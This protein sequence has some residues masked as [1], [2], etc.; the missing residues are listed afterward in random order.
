MKQ[1]L[2]ILFMIHILGSFQIIS[3]QSENNYNPTIENINARKWFQD[4]KFG[5]F[6]HW[7]VYSQLAGAGQTHGLDGEGNINE[8]IMDS[9]R[10]PVNRYERLAGFFNPIHYDPSEWVKL[11]KDAGMKYITFTTKHHDGFSMFGSKVTDYNIVDATS[12][13]KDVFGMLAEECKEQDV[14]LFAYYSHLD[15]HHPDYWPRGRTGNNYTG[16]PES[17]DWDKYLDYVNEQIREIFTNYGPLAGAWFDGIWDKKDADWQ[18]RKTYDIIHELQPAA[19]ILNNHHGDVNPGEDLKGFERAL[20]GQKN[21]LGNKTETTTEHPMEMCQT[22]NKSWGFNLVDTSFKSAKDIVHLLAKA[23]GNDANLLLNVGPQPD[24]RIQSEFIEILGEVGNWL[25]INGESI[26][27][28]RMGPISPQDWGVSTIHA[29]NKKVYIH[30]LNLA[31]EELSIPG[32]GKKVNKATFLKSGKK[33]SLRYSN[34]NIRIRIP[35]NEKDEMNT[36]VILEYS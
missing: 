35:E 36:V 3:A 11:A 6:V 23:A 12:Y 4:A 16:R 2:L 34:G 30:V 5:L 10:I 27:A 31:G 9:K 7:G 24:G 13:K 26:Y 1:K 22:I 19:L 25:K 33:A 21:F 20:P 28:T 17:G 18:L 14:K 15:W 29:E 32:F 8:W